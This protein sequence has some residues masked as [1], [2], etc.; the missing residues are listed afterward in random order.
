MKIQQGA[1]QGFSVQGVA[2][3]LPKFC[4]HI[5]NANS[6]QLFE[7]Y[8]DERV[9]VKVF[10]IINALSAYFVKTLGIEMVIGGDFGIGNLQRE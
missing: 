3:S 4:C 8:V 9:Y 2:R 1:W 5:Q 10:H 7:A 6:M